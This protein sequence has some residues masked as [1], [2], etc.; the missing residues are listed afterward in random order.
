VAK[1]RCEIKEQSKKKMSHNSQ[2]WL[3]LKQASNEVKCGQ[4]IVIGFVPT[5]LLLLLT[6]SKMKIRM[7]VH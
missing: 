3:V 6:A 4:N 5:G 1:S 7:L 2:L